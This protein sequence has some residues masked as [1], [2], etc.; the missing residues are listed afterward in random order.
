MRI[1][2]KNPWWVVVGGIT[3]L[4]VCN[5]PVLAFTFGV[6]LKPIMADMGWQRGTASFALA[7][8][9]FVAA[10]AVPILG[11]MMDRWTIRKVAL[12]GIVAFAACL[13]LMSQT[14]H[15]LPVFTVFFTLTSIAGAVQTPLGYTKAIAAWF[16]RRRGLALGCALAGV[17][18]GG[19]VIPQLANYFIGQFGW[20]GA[21]AILGGMVLVIAFPAVALWVREPRPGEGERHDAYVGTLPGLMPREAAATASF[22][23][24]AA[25]FFFVA[26]AL[27][28][29]SAHVVPLLTDRGLSPT[30]ATATF[31]LFGLST[32]AGRLLSGYLIDRIFAAYVATI[33]WLAP[34]GGFVLLTSGIGLLPALGV[35][36]IG[37]GL[38]TEVDLIAF[39][40]SRYLGLR[41]FGALYGLFFMMFAL[42][43]AFGRFLGGYLFDLAGSYNPAL[44]GAAGSLIVAVILVNRLGAYAYPVHPPQALEL[45]AEPAVP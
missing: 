39:M 20:R 24:L 14:P 41:A 1:A 2:F 21:Y 3:G 8:G 29:S 32:L 5:G 28:G 44:I 36:L 23:I 12:P 31:G 43:G 37:L 16:D 38:G 35:V 25:T 15:S 34:I 11:R 4:F 26:M 6:F 42:G 7:V 13:C 45:A 30:A 17:G 10:F 40:I 9:E 18:L 19:I 22:W 33:F 27:L